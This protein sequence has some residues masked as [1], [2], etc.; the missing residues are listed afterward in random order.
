VKERTMRRTLL[1]MLVPLFAIP[2]CGEDDS[3]AGNGTS[4]KASR[5]AR[6]TP[7]EVYASVHKA[8]ADKDVDGFWS[9]TA[10]E[11]R[12]AMIAE[13]AK[14]VE[15]VKKM[16]AEDRRKA[17]ARL[18]KRYGFQ[19]DLN[20]LTPKDALFWAMKTR[21]MAD[22]ARTD[23][24]EEFGE[25][26]L[27]S[28]AMGEVTYIL[29]EGPAPKRETKGLAI[30][31]QRVDIAIVREDGG[32]RLS[33][34]KRRW[35]GDPI[36]E[37]ATGVDSNASLAFSADGRRLA[38]FTE[39]GSCK[40]WNVADGTAAWGCKV[41]GGPREPTA[42]FSA[43]LTM[44]ATVTPDRKA[45][46]IDTKTGRQLAQIAPDKEDHRPWAFSPDGKVLVTSTSQ[47]PGH[48]VIWST[49]TWRE[50]KRIRSH[51]ERIAA[52]AFSRDGKQ[53]AST[54]DDKLVK[55]RDCASWKRRV[56]LAGHTG[57]IVS[58]TFSRDGKRLVSVS[59]DYERNRYDHDV[60]AW[61]TAD[62][63]QSYK[64]DYFRDVQGAAFVPGSE[65][66]LLCTRYTLMDVDPATGTLL[67]EVPL[68]GNRKTGTWRRAG[69]GLRSAVFSP[70]GRYLAATAR[71]RSP[72]PDRGDGPATEQ[73]GS[74]ERPDRAATEPR[75]DKSDAGKAAPA[76]EDPGTAAPKPVPP[77]EPPPRPDPPA[78]GLILIW[79]V[80][81]PGLQRP[82]G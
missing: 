28:Y 9:L 57:R 55:L 66:L 4:D 25:T 65:R 39:W 56:T 17:A 60:I 2:A 37:I 68:Q 35:R 63:E 24:I 33:D 47:A 49:I 13:M 14:L 15:R 72:K 22:D 78:N 5:Y 61:R 41:D 81:R 32:W 26:F 30:K 6:S 70:D 58:V 77:R 36:R 44:L 48:L 52:V 76:V 29:A 82:K 19:G 12:K 7:E 1:V 69:G 73:P 11:T 53:L 40:V 3:S 8:F 43:D 23:F 20:P 64:I 18:R 27:G 45:V 75:T 59:D 71:T 16:P 54:G 62:G 31:R 80:E 67:R 79:Q 74:A 38:Q 21:I 42:V 34:E 51:K 10:T 50:A 46:V